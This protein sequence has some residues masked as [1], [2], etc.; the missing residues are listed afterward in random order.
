MFSCEKCGKATID[1]LIEDLTNMPKNLSVVCKD[2]RVDYTRIEEEDGTIR[3]YTRGPVNPF[4]VMQ[5]LNPDVSCDFCN[6]A[7]PIWLYDL[8]MEPLTFGDKT[9]DMGTRWATCDACSKDVAEGSPLGTVLRMRVAGDVTHL[10][11][12][13]GEVMQ[14]INNKRAYV[15]DD[16]DGVIRQL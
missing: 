14:H 8:K 16:S 3:G 4:E 15:R 1:I 7:N 9:I 2:C 12:I 10:M 5:Q 11:H 6:K 13:H